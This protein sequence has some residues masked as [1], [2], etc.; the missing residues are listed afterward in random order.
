MVNI[1]A[2]ALSIRKEDV[3]AYPEREVEE[4]SCLLAESLLAERQKGKPFAYIA[5]NKEF[6]SENF[7]VDER[8]L[9]PR[10]DTEVLV[11][12]ALRILFRNPSMSAVLDMGTGSG[13]IG[14]VVAKQSRNKVL[15]SD[16]SLDALCVAR[17]NS[18]R[19]GVSSLTC[20]LCS[21]LFGAVGNMSF[22]MVLA[23]LPYI[24]SEEWGGLM[25]DVK[26]YEPRMALDGGHEGLVIYERFIEALPRHLNRKGHVLCEVGGGNQAE[27][28][29]KMLG[30]VGLTVDTRK[31]LSGN[32][33]VLIGSWI[34]L[35]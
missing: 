24:P 18:R 32:E 7:S 16:I 8:V 25:R 33:R 34:N 4:E 29:G 6:F 9:I 21:D 11:E 20:F 5:G 13:A 10:P 22:D 12:E 15:C 17:E 28:L 3:F 35:S 27:K 23:N 30:T 19:L 1:L 2:V 31:D 14:L 26:D